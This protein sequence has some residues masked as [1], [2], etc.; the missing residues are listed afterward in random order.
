MMKNTLAHHSVKSFVCLLT[1]CFVLLSGCETVE[2]PS[3]P[4]VGSTSVSAVTESTVDCVGSVTSDGG[5]PITTRGF[6]WST[7]I[8]PT[9][10]DDLLAD[11]S[12]IGEF[13]EV[14]AELEPGTTY[15]IRAFATNVAGTAYGEQ[16]TFKTKICSLSTTAPYFIMA[17][18]AISGGF[19]VTDY[20]S[21]SVL[22]RGVCW[23]TFPNPTLSDS[24][25]ID[26]HGK[27]GFT[28]AM[29][30]LKPLT[31]YYVRSYVT[32]STGVTYGN[33]LNFTTQSGVISLMTEPAKNITAVSA[34]FSGQ[35]SGDGGA[36]V[37]E[38]GFVWSTSVLPSTSDHKVRS[39]SI[40][41]VFSCNISNLTPNNTY[42]LRSYAINAAGTSYGNEL[43]FETLNGVISMTTKVVSG[44]STS[45]AFSGGT[46]SSD[47]GSSIVSRGVCW[48]EEPSPTSSL[49]TKTSNSSGVGSFS[50]SI[51]GLSPGRLYYVRAYAINA[52]GTSY[53]NELT[54]GTGTG[55][56]S[57]T[58]N[59]VSG[60]TT[61]SAISGGNISSDGG[62]NVIGRGVC[63]SEESSPT[64]S[65]TTKTSNSSGLGSFSSSLTGLSPGR[66]YY[67][68][69]YATNS[70]GTS[71]GAEQSFVTLA[72][73][74]YVTTTQAT[75]ITSSS[76]MTGGLVTTD[77][78]SIVT[79]RGVCWSTYGD[80]LNYPNT[81]TLNGAGVGSFVSPLT[82]LI[83]GMN[84]WVRAYATNSAGTAYG[85]LI[86][87]LTEPIL[88]SVTTNE[89]TNLTAFSAS[90]SGKVN[91]GGGS[92][93]A[94][95]GICWG[96]AP[97]PTIDDSKIV[98]GYGMGTFPISLTGLKQGTT[99]HARAFATNAVGVAYGNDVVFTTPDAVINL[100]TTAASTISTTSVLLGGSI[101]SVGGAT[102]T[103][104][105]VCW[106]I[107]PH[108]T[109]SDGQLAIASTSDTY[110]G[111]VTGLT[112]D[113]KYYVRSFATNA[114]GTYYGNEI[115]FSTLPT[116]GTI[117]DI[118]GNVYHYITIGT[119]TWTVENLRTTKY[120]TGAPIPQVADSAQWV[121]LGSGAYCEYTDFVN[122]PV[123]YGRLYNW[124]AVN[125]SR[126]L[127]PTGWHVPTSADWN[128]LF[129]YLGGTSVAGAKLKEAGTT[130]WASPNS[131]ATNSSG[132]TAL[133][134]GYRH[135]G[136]YYLIGSYGFSWIAT[137]ANS[138]T[139]GSLEFGYWT[140]E[141][142]KLDRSKNTGMSVRCIR[143]N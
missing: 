130:H 80:P 99:Y 25:T 49:A 59:V 28:S 3:I 127:A 8:N 12:G 31:T 19:L 101:N 33:E 26:G 44:I 70:V 122:L 104:R 93:V 15:F 89:A 96:V 40:S 14:I 72:T 24:T 110:S 87:F 17:T 6:C 35:L 16:A 60:I 64:V 78:S 140:S 52:A 108:P 51:T 23:N 85:N 102:V 100:T 118:D 55:A 107:N 4:I 136:S 41:G 29:S 48:S 133:P 63:W 119:Q 66:L 117:S 84:Y 77:G 142:A 2:P 45:A 39:E 61:T 71:Y 22:A 10:D 11:S 54:F 92:S 137:E 95:R 79:A 126:K 138:T 113:T 91:N 125:D 69:A 106:S 114:V 73:L 129:T 132:F 42:Y 123:S 13:Q 74:P 18:S 1:I 67:V 128:L 141:V 115:S 94:T 58:T 83:F 38:C 86:S 109:L 124:Y 143:D 30:N 135:N 111:K 53:G 57:L 20:D 37:T 32:T 65:L 9:L 90:I 82:N 116:T 46:I 139:A 47:G 120:N 27:G 81:L 75:E 131:G 62:S 112:A 43:T 56:I 88:A 97:N 34:T 121:S 68:R 7:K 76:A 134:T 50:S 36:V 21:A 105:G 5:S 98:S 103:S